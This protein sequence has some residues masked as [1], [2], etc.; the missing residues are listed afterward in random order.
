MLHHIRRLLS[1]ALLL[2]SAF[3]VAFARTGAH[4]AVHKSPSAGGRA[5]VLRLA[6]LDTLPKV[7]PALV[8]DDENVQLANLL[9]VGLVRLDASYRVVPAAAYK[10]TVSR[11]HKTYTFSLRKNLRF[12][13]GHPLTARDFA[14][15]MSRSLNPAV[16]SSAAPTYLLDIRGAP[17][18]LSGKTKK[19]SGIR[20]VDN[21]TL[22][23]TARWAVPYFLMELT[24]PTAFAL[25]S[26]VL[27]KLGG[28]ESS[29]WYS[30]PVS[31][32]PYRLK[33]WVTGSKMILVPNKY[34]RLSH[35]A[36]KQIVISLAPL[37]DKGLYQYVSQNL[38]VVALPAGDRTLTHQSF[39][40]QTNMLA[41]DGLYMKVGAKPFDSRKVRQALDLSIDRKRIVAATKGSSV[42]AWDGLTSPE[43]VKGSSE[44]GFIHFDPKRAEKLW[45]SS[46]YVKKKLP[47]LTLYYIDDPSNAKLANAIVRSWH[48]YLKLSVTTQA[49]TPNTLVADVQSNSLPLY[50]S[51]WSAD[52]PDQHDWVALQWESDALNNN[53]QYHNPRFDRIVMTADVTWDQTRRTHLYAEAQRLLL[54]DAAWIPLYV[55]HRLVFIRP[56]VTNLALTGYGLIPKS[57][58][59][60][61]V[62]VQVP[63][64]HRRAK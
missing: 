4:A 25:D 44:N 57:G 28:I 51:G 10:W 62:H 32:G 41:G 13:N 58:S 42:T 55:P 45:D 17:A 59:W 39:I 61:D 24:Y 40:A 46:P 33:S 12:S 22:R 49:L 38:D 36:L 1:A 11:D 2:V 34:Y 7:D 30:N 6:M 29:A 48:K 18:M 3:A 14:Y 47:Q 21:H 54:E 23:I 15:A 31:S 64:A 63:A 43:Q 5:G 53:V 8:T 27:S 9:Y 50:L 20:V 37:P 26:R 16:K 35:P 52:Y 56:T 19:V 60:A